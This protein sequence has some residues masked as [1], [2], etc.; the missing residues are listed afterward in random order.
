MKRNTQIYMYIDHATD[1]TPQ[2]IFSIRNNIILKIINHDN[3]DD[4]NYDDDDDNDDN[5]LLLR[6]TRL[7]A[8][9]AGRVAIIIIMK[10]LNNYYFLGLL[11]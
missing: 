4:E 2:V 10:I 9:H 3:D 8:P 5:K 7:P 1:R 6:V 11:L